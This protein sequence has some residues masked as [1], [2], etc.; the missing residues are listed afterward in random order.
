MSAGRPRQ[1]KLPIPTHLICG[2]GK[3][4]TIQQLLRAKQAAGNT[5]VWA[6]LVN[7]FGALGIDAAVLAGA[8]AAVRELAGGC[9][10][11]T[12]P[13]VTVAA[14]VQLIRAAKP[15]RL[16]LEPSGLAHPDALLRLL[17]GAHL[18]T[19][20]DIRPITCLVDLATFDPGVA[21]APSD[22]G[23]GT[24]WA[25]IGVADV[26]IG[27]KP[28]VCG[29][30][31]VEAFHRWA[32]KLDPPKSRVLARKIAEISAEDVGIEA[33]GQASGEALE[34]T[35]APVSRGPGRPGA[36][37]DVWL[38]NA[39]AEGTA[40]APGRPLRK[41]GGGD[42][43]E[44]TT[45]GWVFHADDVFRE[46]DLSW[47]VADAA[48]HVLRLKGIF[49]TGLHP[50][51]WVL[52]SVGGAPGGAAPPQEL[53]QELPGE[54]RDSRVE[55]IVAAAA[56]ASADTSSV[57]QLMRDRDWAGVEAMLL[58]LLE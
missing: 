32:E 33:G 18:A 57:G 28:D 6:V 53:L 46:K 4:S 7:E 35:A 22:D 36:T 12:M 25:Q 54:Q 41:P 50:P 45:C 17:R 11:C 2:S 37:R 19:A 3:T 1:L 27:T 30:V 23:G 16:L 26:L 34:R 21:G 56:G 47:F 31:G 40:A 55:V 48:P 44:P 9:L 43:A 15:D 52:S 39:A 29:A 24:F 20:L 13:T 14:L 38:S 58:G 42:G 49:R 8:G 10:C 51:R 5:E